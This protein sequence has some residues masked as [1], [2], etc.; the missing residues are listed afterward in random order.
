MIDNLVL[1]NKEGVPVTN[2]LLVVTKFNKGHADVFRAIRNLE[3]GVSEVSENKQQ[4]NFALLQ[5][6]IETGNGGWQD[7]LYYKDFFNLTDTAIRDITYLFVDDY[8][9]C[10]I[11]A[12]YM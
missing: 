12:G 5:N 8:A 11:T 9:G 2:S 3:V 4:R 10:N 6:I 7:Q 1:K